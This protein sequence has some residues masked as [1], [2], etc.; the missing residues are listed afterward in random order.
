MTRAAFTPKP[1]TPGAPIEWREFIPGTD[2]ITGHF[3]TRTGQV[4]SLAQPRGG[5]ACL[6]AI[7]D[8]RSHVAVALVYRKTEGK[9]LHV[10]ATLSHEAQR[11][12][13]R[14]ADALH[15]AGTIEMTYHGP[16]KNRLACAPGEWTSRPVDVHLPGCPDT[17]RF[18]TAGTGSAWPV[19]A[20]VLGKPSYAG[21]PAARHINFCPACLGAVERSQPCAA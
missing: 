5:R 16:R 10:A 20:Y 15:A 13:I 18:D 4:W 3:L 1:F 6:W 12:T 21:H 9:V 11:L 7:P 17:R 2:T 8:D 19:L 14:R